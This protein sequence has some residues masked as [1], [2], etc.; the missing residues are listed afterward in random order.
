[1]TIEDWGGV[2]C[3]TGYWDCECYTKYIHRKAR[4]SECHRCGTNAD[5]QPPSRVIE[6][7]YMYDINNGWR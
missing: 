7:K 2:M 6:I 3:D 4:L 5:D 1:M